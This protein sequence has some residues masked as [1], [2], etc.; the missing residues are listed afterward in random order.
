MTG[1]I[2]PYLYEIDAASLENRKVVR[3]SMP[4]GVYN[5]IKEAQGGVADHAMAFS[6]LQAVLGWAAP[7]VDLVGISGPSRIAQKTL[8]LTAI[9]PAK[10]S[11]EIRREIEVAV[12]IWLGIVV[13]EKAT[14]ITA[15]LTDGRS[16]RG[17]ACVEQTIRAALTWNGACACPADFA[18][19][20]LISLVAARALEDQVLNRE[21]P[22]E[23]KLVLSGA[24]QSLYFGKS[25]QRYEPS[26]VD[27]KRGTGWWTEL[28][29]VAAVST[30]ESRN[31]RVAINV[32]TRNFG[33][34]H[35]ARLGRHRARY[36]DVFVPA[37]PALAPGSGRIRCVELATTRRDWWNAGRGEKGRESPDRR[38]LK[39]IL[40]MSGLDF[41]EAA[42]GLKPLVGESI[43]LY[44]RFGTV[45]GDQWAP[46]GTGVSHPEREEYLAFLDEHLGAS[47]FTRVRMER[48]TK[49]GPKS[50]VTPLGDEPAD[51]QAALSR[52]FGNAGAT[53]SLL[54]SRP[55]G[56]KLF[57]DAIQAVLGEPRSI[58][59]STWTF[60]DGFSLCVRH[61]PAGPFAQLLDAIDE[62]KVVNTPKHLQYKVKDAIRDERDTVARENMVAYLDNAFQTLPPAW[63]GLVEMNE[64]LAEDGER[65]PYL[66]AY[67]TIAKKGGVA[68]VKLFNPEGDQELDSLDGEDSAVGSDSFA[69]QNSILD[70]FR[71]AGVSPVQD[72]QIRLSAWWVINLNDRAGDRQAGAKGGFCT[73]LYIECDNGS[74]SVCLM[75]RDDEPVRCTYSE[76]IRLIA[77]GN[78]ANLKFVKSEEQSTRIAQFLAQ[79]TPRDG[80]RTVLFVEA[81]N[82]RAAVPG[83]RNSGQFAFDRLQLGNVGGAA[84][85]REILPSD[86]LS[87]VRITDE[88]AKAPCYWVEQNTQGTTTGIFREPSAT[89][90]YWISRGLPTPLQISARQANKKSR[91]DQGAGQYKHRRFPSLSEVTVVV[92]SEDESVWDL[93]ALTRAMMQCHIATDEKTILP[94]PLHEGALLAGAAR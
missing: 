32:G 41:D 94:F 52:R 88:S 6:G 49:R 47:G 74:I 82:I 36:M 12:S 27:R 65:D 81:T 18:L 22:N 54:Q 20:D 38:V 46:G 4:A 40:G 59:D 79:A 53:M 67:Q 35:E 33:E 77:T 60:G 86:G 80:R 91:H 28:F 25:L 63:M 76:A 78:V 58:S 5:A 89:R 15:M 93:V 69:Y 23:G 75:G 43:G 37:N 7:S 1:I 57:D 39:T 50:L 70:L 56:A 2:H 48:V 17:A 64:A 9:D 24:Q 34:I 31:L 61:G 87:I 84:P 13:P 90:T 21:T 62:T 11:D 14:E 26:R 92:K 3:Y 44:P 85:V 19:F 66:L 16:A 71:S 45:H 72:Q 55:N 8:M 51:L 68:Q 83:F 10:S 30:P 73:P 29:N 42:L